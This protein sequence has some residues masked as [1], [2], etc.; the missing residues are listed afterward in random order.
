MNT[1]NYMS[2]CIRSGLGALLLAAVVAVTPHTADAN[3]AANAL[4]HNIAI[5]NYKDAG[6]TS[7]TAITA[8]ADVIVTLVASAPTLSAPVD[9]NT[10]PGTPVTYNYTIT[11]TA[12]GPDTYNLSKTIAESAGITT[13]TSTAVVSPSVVLGASTIAAPVTISAAG[14]TA[15]VVPSDGVA[16]G[17][18]NGI[19]LGNTVVI[20]GAAYTVASVVDNAA[21][22][23][24]I[25]VTGNGIASAALPYGTLI[26][27]RQSFTVLVTP[28]T[29]TA[30][31]TQTVTVNLTATSVADGTKSVTDQ[32]VTTVLV[33]NLTVVKEVSKDGVSWSAAT[34]AAPGTPL[35]YRISV[36]NNG[37]S[38]ATSVVITDPLTTY[39]SYVLGSGKRATGAAVSYAAA[40]TALT[41][42]A[43]GDGYDW[44]VTTAGT[45]TYAVGTLATGLVNMVQLFFQANVR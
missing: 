27:Q 9:Q 7:Q 4:I 17:S 13:G 18:V 44:S 39:T 14:T 29:V 32:T 16:G 42:G 35:Y 21:G 3:T 19:A 28:G 43:D 11:A 33:A 41:D 24:T 1:Q 25:T 31:T 23:S 22:T 8:S 37:G 45:V 2:I 26:A 34:T 5:V 6:G 36:T 10:T 40:A 30:N 38:N 15:I 20:A 12:N